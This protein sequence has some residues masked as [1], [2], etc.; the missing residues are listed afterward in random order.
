MPVPCPPALFY[1]STLS[2]GDLYLLWGSGVNTTSL[3]PSPRLTRGKIYPNLCPACPRG[4][5]TSRLPPSWCYKPCPGVHTLLT[6][7]PYI[8]KV[9][10]CVDA[11]AW[12]CVSV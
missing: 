3:W 9:P 10:S 8:N 5:P 2:W 12:V 11:H 7:K 6:K 4:S 1:P